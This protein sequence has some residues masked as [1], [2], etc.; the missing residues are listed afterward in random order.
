MPARRI[1]PRQGNKIFYEKKSPIVWEKEDRKK[2][3]HFGVSLFQEN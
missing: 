1:N 3:A 2:R